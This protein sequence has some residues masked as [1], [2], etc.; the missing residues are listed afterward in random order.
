MDHLALETTQKTWEQGAGLPGTQERAR[1]G[2]QEAGRAVLRGGARRLRG[3]SPPTRLPGLAGR[4]RPPSP[5]AQCSGL[6]EP[7]TIWHLP[8]KVL[9]QSPAVLGRR[10][11]RARGFAWLWKDWRDHPCGSGETGREFVPRPQFLLSEPSAPG[12]A[13]FQQP[14]GAPANV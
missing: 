13:L 9:W 8:L 11:S 12:R 14:P 1:A 2:S 4:L 5:K 3:W 10:G 7:P 6:R